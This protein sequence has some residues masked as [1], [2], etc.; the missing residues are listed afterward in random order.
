MH[1]DDNYILQGGL[2]PLCY[3]LEQAPSRL[4]QACRDVKCRPCKDTLLELFHL[5]PV[6]ILFKNYP[7]PVMSI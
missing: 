5:K 3:S 6:H 4:L 1:V 7:K 2:P